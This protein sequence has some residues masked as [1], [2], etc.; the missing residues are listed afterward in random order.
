MPC[1][2]CC[3]K[4]KRRAC[5][6]PDFSSQS[7]RLSV[8]VPVENMSAST[9]SERIVEADALQAVPDL[10]SQGPFGKHVLLVCDDA[11]WVAAGQK[12]QTILQAS[13]YHVVPHS[14][15]RTVQASLKYIEPILAITNEQGIDA[16]I[17]VGSGTINDITKYA[18]YQFGQPY[19]CVATAASMN[20]YSSATAS[21]LDGTVKHSY[22]CRNP[23]AVVA[24]LQIIANAPRRLARAGVGDT[25][26]RSTVAADRYISHAVLGTPFERAIFEQLRT[27]EPWLMQNMALL[28]DG[29]MEYMR[30][31]MHA[32]LDAGDAM[33]S[34]QSSV[35]ASQGEHMIAHTL[36]MMYGKELREVL[37]GE[38]IAV[39]TTTMAHLQ[40]KILLSQPTLRHHPRE[41]AQFTRLFGKHAAPELA[42]RYEKKILREA[43]ITALDAQF[44][45]HWPDIK[46]E[47][48]SMIVP[49]NGIERAFKEA[50][51]A[52]TAKALGLMEERYNSAVTYAYMTRE[53]FTFLDLAAMNARRT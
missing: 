47:L 16:M 33:T 14:L 42:Q 21:L 27:H 8:S 17:A 22:V 49:A 2:R 45:R 7:K 34:T 1:V 11:T 53:R 39:T 6:S 40:H 35:V 26:C 48:L 3:G 44:Q 28:R 5:A 32:L 9:Q 30:H 31:L 12:L 43:E 50:G 36:E 20:G 4:T 52:T 19:L 41:E 24:D 51:I 18:A 46:V 29:S 10:L 25:L 37:H 13:G 38:M 15:G 23:Y